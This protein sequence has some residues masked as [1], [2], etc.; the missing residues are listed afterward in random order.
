MDQLIGNWSVVR[1]NGQAICSLTMTNNDAGNDNFQLFIKPRCDTA[2]A[3]FAPVMWRLERGELIWMSQKGDVWRF[4]ADDNA[5]WRRVPDSADPL[6]L[7]R[8]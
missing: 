2:I 7:M 5:Q 3:N 4:E 6:I 8:Q 1:G